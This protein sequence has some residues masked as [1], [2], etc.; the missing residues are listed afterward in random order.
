MPPSPVLHRLQRA[1]A[2]G[3]AVDP[4]LAPSTSQLTLADPSSTPRRWVCV[5]VDVAGRVLGACA[6]LDTGHPTYFRNETVMAH[7]RRRDENPVRYCWKLR[8]RVVSGSD[9]VMM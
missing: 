7:D 4:F 6:C 3:I 8:L 5:T 1:S 9:D 2:R